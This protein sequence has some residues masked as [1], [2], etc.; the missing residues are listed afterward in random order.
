MCVSGFRGVGWGERGS[1]DMWIWGYGEQE[2]DGENEGPIYVSKNVWVPPPTPPTTPANHT[3]QP[4]LPH[5]PHPPQ[6]FHTHR[7]SMGH[8]AAM[9]ISRIRRRM[10]STKSMSGVGGSAVPRPHNPPS[11]PPPFSFAS[12][13]GLGWSA[14]AAAAGVGAGGMRPMGWATSRT[15]CWPPQSKPRILVDSSLR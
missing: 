15:H 3:H 10:A 9:P 6:P 12:A 7:C 14:A 8:G 4:T 13:L 5:P 1:V 2:E 11:H